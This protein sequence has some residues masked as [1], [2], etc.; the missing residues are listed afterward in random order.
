MAEM[1][2]WMFGG[3]PRI[4]NRSKYSRKNWLARPGGNITG[5]L[6]SEAGMGGKRRVG[7]HRSMT[8]FADPAK[9]QYSSCEQLAVHRQTWTTKEQELKQLMDRADQGAGG[10]LV[11][12]LA[13]KADYVAA[14][15]ELKAA[16]TC[17]QSI[18]LHPRTGAAT[19]R[20]TEFAPREIPVRHVSRPGTSRR[21]IR[22]ARQ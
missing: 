8:F 15:E 20:Y 18:A 12:V 9:Y 4:P 17:E 11:N 5:F 6:F 7:A 22:C 10:A 14:T 16:G 2:G 1:C 21:A 19:P 3:A 13:Y